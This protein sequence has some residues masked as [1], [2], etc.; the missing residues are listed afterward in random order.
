[1]VMTKGDG[2]EEEKGRRRIGVSGGEGNE[3]GE[4]R[5]GGSG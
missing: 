2:V 5:E 1:M 4:G 3:G